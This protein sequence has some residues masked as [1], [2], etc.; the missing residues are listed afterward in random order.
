MRIDILTL[1]PEIFSTPLGVSIVGRAQENNIVEIKV[2][3]IRQFSHDKHGKVDDRPYGGGPGMVIKPEPIFE[4]VESVK[5]GLRGQVNR[6]ILMTPQGETFSQRKA[7]E[8]SSEGNL[9]IICGRYEGVDERVREDLVTEEISI[10]D[11][12]IS[13]GE[14]AAMVVVEAV[15]RLLPGALGDENS[16]RTDSFSDPME[17]PFVTGLEYPQYTRPPEYRGMKVPPVL[18]LGNH[19]EIRKWRRREALRR[20]VQR[21]P[22]VLEKIKLTEEDKKFLEEIKGG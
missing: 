8:L 11:Y 4:A 22:D 12:V 21:R 5:K 14:L 3:D 10:G 17:N 7:I 20:T 1:F 13:G 6:V 15:V 18:C 2:H 19:E 16:A 9:I